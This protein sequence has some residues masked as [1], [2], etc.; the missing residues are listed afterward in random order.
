MGSESRRQFV[1]PGRTRLAERGELD[2]IDVRQLG[3][4]IRI[5]TRPVVEDSPAPATGPA[6]E[7]ET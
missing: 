3:P 6:T 7:T 2:V 1:T 5:T 4:D